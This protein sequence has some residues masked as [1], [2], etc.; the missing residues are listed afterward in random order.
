VVRKPIPDAI[1]E[2]NQRPVA[3]APAEMTVRCGQEFEIDGS[4]SS[5]PEGQPLYYRW[6]EKMPRPPLDLHQGPILRLQAPDKPD[7]IEYRLWVLDGLRCS[8]PATIKVNVVE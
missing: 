2:T 4:K 1:R 5:D 8:E 3:V 7:T 6:S